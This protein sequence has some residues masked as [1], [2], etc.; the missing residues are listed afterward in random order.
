MTALPAPLTLRGRKRRDILHGRTDS[1]CN[2]LLLLPLAT[3][4]EHDD[5]FPFLEATVACYRRRWPLVI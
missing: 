2:C 3:R 5:R 4:A 1:G